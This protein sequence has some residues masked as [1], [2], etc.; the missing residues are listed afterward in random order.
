MSGKA[1]KVPTIFAAVD[2]T[3]KVV[4]AIGVGI[5][6]FAA[7]TEAAF[8]RVDR[9]IARVGRTIKNTLG[10]LGLFV[11]LTAG[12]AVLGGAVTVIA[13]YEQANANLA[14]VL[15]KNVSE[16]IALQTAS[17]QLG[18][19]TAFTAAEVTGLQ[20][21][22][23]KLGFAQQEILG[24]T[25]ATLALAS[26]TN[27]E[28]PQAAAQVG[29]AIRAFSLDASEATRVADVFAKSTSLS[30]LDM[31]KLDVAMSKVAPVSKQFG[32]SIED[33]TAL[34]GKL[35]DAG[36]DAS[37]MAT[38]TRSIILNLADGNGK[39]AK[40][41]GGPA[42][43]LPEITKAMVKMRDRG[44]DLADML[45][46]TDERSVAAFATLLEGA[47]GID[48]L[49]GK[50]RNAGGAAEEMARKQLDTLTGRVTI[51][52]SAYQGFILSLDDG[53]GT[54]SQTA[55][56]VLDVAT[57]ILSLASGMAVAREELTGT[58]LANRILAERVIMV[59]KVIGAMIAA[60]LSMKVVLFAVRTA[61]TAYNIVV[62]ISS[63]LQGKNFL[64]LRRNTVALKA[65]MVMTKI[66]A[67]AQKIFNFILSANPI[68][69]VI[70]AITALIFIVKKMIDNWNTW[71][72]VMALLMGPI[73]LIIFAVK[74]VADRWN[75]VKSSF[76]DGGIL[77]ALS[78]IGEILRDALVVA[79]AEGIIMAFKFWQFIKSQWPA[80]VDAVKNKFVE[81]GK[82]IVNAVLKPVEA[83]LALTSKIG[84]G[85]NALESVQ[86][87]RGSNAAEIAEL[88]QPSETADQKGF[89][90][91]ILA[92]VEKRGIEEGII[93]PTNTQATQERNITERS[94]E[95]SEG[96]LNINVNDPN[97][98]V[99][100]DESEVG[101]IP[102]T[103]QRTGTFD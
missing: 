7:K 87:I 69:L 77:S 73:G 17:K 18:A 54:F 97:G 35:S 29:A 58:A 89:L 28:L 16:T 31:T 63:A 2:R 82:V 8:A 38:S 85:T 33:T 67:A 48:T 40:A 26:A 76:Q 23:A 103:T 60:Y 94:E 100:V 19:T 14:A 41:L 101:D 12:L 34:M 79:I 30:A 56:R 11:G 95:V 96:R 57:E 25:S 49:A 43:T 22:Y 9:R 52:K 78:K 13:D 91:E 37:T 99:E 75:E 4:R 47:E 86:K 20:T 53:N 84:I 88:R 68:G 42:R 1:F 10:T 21:E 80:A 5:S 32:F 65:H 36:F 24:A 83:V 93:P 72:Q 71:G 102:V 62:G 50:L 3:T 44:I 39:L 61:T 98:A 90:D 74:S 15:G 66:A 51:L 6:K 27:T 81:L 45:G 46:V 70:I 55:K 59:V 64:L 92:Q